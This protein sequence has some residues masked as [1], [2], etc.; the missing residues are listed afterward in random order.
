MSKEKGE[1][2][3]VFFALYSVLCTLYSS[4]FTFHLSVFTFHLLQQLHNYTD[5]SLYTPVIV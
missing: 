1:S 2:R 4:L 5:Y 3:N